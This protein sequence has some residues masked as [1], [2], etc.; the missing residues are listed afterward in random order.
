MCVCESV[1]VLCGLCR[2]QICIM[3]MGMTEVLLQFEGV[4]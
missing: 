3:T 4:L 1:R 2:T